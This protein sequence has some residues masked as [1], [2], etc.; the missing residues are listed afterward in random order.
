MIKEKSF[1][2]MMDKSTSSELKPKAKK[3][4]KNKGSQF[5]KKDISGTK[6]KGKGNCLHCGKPGHWKRNCQVYL[7]PLKKKNPI[8]DMLINF[9]DLLECPLNS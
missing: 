3:F 6:K 5:K 4:K 2:M 9:F 8:E 7:A 1:L